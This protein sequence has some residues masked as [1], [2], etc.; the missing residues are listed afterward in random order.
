MNLEGG[1]ADEIKMWVKLHAWKNDIKWVAV[2][3]LNMDQFLFP[4]FVHTP[5]D[6]EGIKQTGI[7]EKI[8][9]ALQ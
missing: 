8:I 1:R 7:K 2:D 9:K 6:F 5:S 4:N 3:D